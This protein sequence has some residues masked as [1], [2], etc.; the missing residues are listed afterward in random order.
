M[1]QGKVTGVLNKS[2]TDVREIARL[3]VGRE[4]VFTVQKPPAKSS[5]VVLQG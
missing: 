2:E 5:D 1:R 3:M 4:V